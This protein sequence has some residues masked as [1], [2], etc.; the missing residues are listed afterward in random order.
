M[1]C[2]NNYKRHK[3]FVIVI[4]FLFSEYIYTMFYDY[5]SQNCDLPYKVLILIALMEIYEAMYPVQPYRNQI[6][7]K[8]TGR[9][10]LQR[11]PARL[12]S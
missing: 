12:R 10:V 4:Y 7:V 6:Y 8:F 2:H 3:N 11:I 9:N 5:I 1:S